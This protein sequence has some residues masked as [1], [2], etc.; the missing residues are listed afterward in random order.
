MSVVTVATLMTALV[1]IANAVALS[2][3]GS[4]RVNLAGIYLL[5]I[6][7]HSFD[8]SPLLYL[9]WVLSAVITIPILPWPLAIV[10]AVVAVLG[11][12]RVLSQYVE[13]THP[14]SFLLLVFVFFAVWNGLIMILIWIWYSLRA[15]EPPI[16]QLSWALTGIVV[17]SALMTGCILLLAIIESWIQRS[18]LSAT[19]QHYY[20]NVGQPHFRSTSRIG[21]W[22]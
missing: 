4:I 11:L 18:S 7:F 17:D 15:I 2:V 5:F 6:V 14:G 9:V 22:I 20:E 16:L 13:H 3:P 21:N 12:R 10:A 19:F 8:R 1:L